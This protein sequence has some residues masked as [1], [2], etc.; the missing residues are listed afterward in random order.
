MEWG[1]LIIVIL[2][3]LLTYVVLQGTRAQL[4]WRR[5]A[6]QGDIPTIR[7][8]VEEALERWRTAPVPRGVSPVLWRALQATELVDVG[9]DHAWV[10][11]TAQGEYSTVAGQRQQVKS[12]LEQGMEITTKLVDMLLYDIP[13]LK[14][15]WVRVDIFAVFTSAEGAA[16]E[17]CILSTTAH[18]SAAVGLDW[19]GL[20]PREIVDHF[21][22]YYRLSDRGVA[23]PI[24]DLSALPQGTPPPRVRLP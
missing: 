18:R 4:E 8:M 21:G 10:N 12:A 5:M 6:A 20:S 2:G 11:C 13:N 19:E 9:A 7:R 16:Q 15:A 22:G 23:L 24:D 14:L 17:R 3:L 1:V